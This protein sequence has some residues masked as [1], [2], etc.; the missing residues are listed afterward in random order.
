MN[1]SNDTLLCYFTETTGEINCNGTI[2]TLH[3]G[4]E[5]AIEGKVPPTS[6]VFY[7]YLLVYIIL[8]LFAGM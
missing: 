1:T 4:S 5:A 6:W 7:V 3:G 2:Y 8:V